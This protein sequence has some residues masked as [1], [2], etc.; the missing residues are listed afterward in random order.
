MDIK[1]NYLNNNIGSKFLNENSTRQSENLI[2]QPITLSFIKNDKNY[3]YL[4]LKINSITFS[5]YDGKDFE[6][7]INIDILNNNEDIEN[8]K[9]NQKF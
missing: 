8:Q 5:I 3:N 7:K 4:N 1:E 2:K 9:K 6:N